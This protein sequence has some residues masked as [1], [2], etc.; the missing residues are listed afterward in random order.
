MT[1]TIDLKP[2][3]DPDSVCYA[4]VTPWNSGGW[5]YATDGHV[6]VRI[7]TGD[8]DT[9]DDKRR[10]AIPQEWFATEREWKWTTWPKRRRCQECGGAGDRQTKCDHCS[11]A[12]RKRCADCDGTGLITL[13]CRCRETGKEICGVKISDHYAWLIGRLPGVECHVNDA[14]YPDGERGFLILR[15]DGGEGVIVG[16][17][18]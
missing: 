4:L 12:S 6:L 15:F 16:L 9:S 14:P 8:P 7:P 3:C 11:A 10:P 13:D 17:A 5:T 2:F 18:K 1:K